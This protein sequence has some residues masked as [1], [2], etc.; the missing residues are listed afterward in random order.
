MHIHSQSL[1]K[2]K[3]KDRKAESLGIFKGKFKYLTEQLKEL[4]TGTRTGRFS[5]EENGANGFSE[6][7]KVP[8][9]CFFIR[10]GH[11]VCVRV[12]AKL[13]KMKEWVIVLN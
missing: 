9:P 12:P 5:S 8:C 2:T 1:F 10:K 7:G 3:R 4:T 11:K 6:I 13:R